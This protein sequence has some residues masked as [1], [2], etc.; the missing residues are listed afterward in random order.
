MAK[1][2]LTGA[3]M[4]LFEKT[5]KRLEELLEIISGDKTGEDAAHAMLDECAKWAFEL[6]NLLKNRS[7]NVRHHIYTIRNRGC[8]PDDPEFYRHI[9]PIEDLLKFI[10]DTHANADPVD[11][12]IEHEF[13]FSVYSR[14]W[15]HE[16]TYHVRRTTKGWTFRY[17][18]PEKDSDMRGYPSLYELLDH[19]LINYPNKLPDYLESLWERAQEQGLAHDEIQKALSELAD[20]VNVCEKSSPASF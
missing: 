16:D 2:D 17:M 9:H 11:Q 5:H 10:D 6:H 19:D 8:S 7:I 12:T 20:W 15:G 1:I 3:E 14:R 13:V 18:T 4:T